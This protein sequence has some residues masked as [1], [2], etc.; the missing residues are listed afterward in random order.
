MDAD[1]SHK[2]M[3]NTLNTMK[4]LKICGDSKLS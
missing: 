3:Q 4:T 2:K 1:Y